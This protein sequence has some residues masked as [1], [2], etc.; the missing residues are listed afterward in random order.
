MIGSTPFHNFVSN[1]SNISNGVEKC[2]KLEWY[3]VKKTFANRP[4]LYYLP[5]ISRC[6]TR[7]IVTHVSECWRKMS[8]IHQTSGRVYDNWTDG[9]RHCI[10][11]FDL[12]CLRRQF[13]YIHVL[14]AVAFCVPI[15][16]W[17]SIQMV[18]V[19][20]DS[21][22][23]WR[24]VQLLCCSDNIVFCFWLLLYE[25]TLRS[26]QLSH[27]VGW[28]WIRPKFQQIPEWT[29]RCLRKFIECP[30]ISLRSGWPS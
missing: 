20:H 9:I 30:Q 8:S 1:N 17:L 27:W 24:Y 28:C 2:V 14:S 10:P 15:Q 19:L 29:N 13:R 22:F 3:T 5:S 7:C 21:A 26:F 16:L 25:R 4:L 23:N 18:F 6:P 11:V 12:L